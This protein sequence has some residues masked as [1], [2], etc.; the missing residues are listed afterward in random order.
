MGIIDVDFQYMIFEYLLLEKKLEESPNGLKKNEFTRELFRRGLPNTYR[1]FVFKSDDVKSVTHLVK[2]QEID[3]NITLKNIE[4]KNKDTVV[5]DVSVL[6]ENLLKFFDFYIK[7]THKYTYARDIGDEKTLERLRGNENLGRIYYN[8]E[9]DEKFRFYP[10]YK[11]GYKSTPMSWTREINLF[12]I[13]ECLAK[14]DI[15]FEPDKDEEFAS[16]ENICF[17]IATWFWKN[18]KRPFHDIY[19]EAR[20]YYEKRYEKEGIVFKPLEKKLSELRIP[21]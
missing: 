20:K 4:Q 17:T 15:W 19:R 16:K 21:S 18:F 3:K 13:G 2:L 14:Y 6:V 9:G 10:G 7:K 8:L 12:K 5:A 11:P 1:N